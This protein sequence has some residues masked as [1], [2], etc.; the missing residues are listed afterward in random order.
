[1]GELYTA[2]GSA[3]PRRLAL[4][5][6]L[7]PLAAVARASFQASAQVSE[8]SRDAS[9]IGTATLTAE[10]A[11]RASATAPE[12]QARPLCPYPAEAHCNDTGSTHDAANSGCG[13]PAHKCRPPPCADTLRL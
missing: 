1:M 10:G 11:R 6:R 5:I 9:R 4:K 7:L 13:V 2:E 8:A 12:V 3:V